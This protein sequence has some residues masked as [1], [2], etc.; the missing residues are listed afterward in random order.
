MKL[1]YC[2]I[3]PNN[4]SI[5]E[6][7]QEIIRLK[8]IKDDNENLQMALKI[9]INSA[10][11]AIGNQY[12]QCY[13]TDVAEAITTQGQ[14]LLMY[15]INSINNYFKEEWHLDKELHDK[16]GI[17][18]LHQLT[19]DAVKY[20]DTDSSYVSFEEA[21]DSVIEWKNGKIDPIEFIRLVYKHRLND[22]FIKM[23]EKYAKKWNTE[24]LHEFEMESISYAGIWTSK[25]KY[26]L[27]MAW[28]D[29]GENGI[30]YKPQQK[31]YT[32]GIE[33][34]QSSYPTF[35]R[36]SLF[37]LIKFII[38]K[39]KNF[40]TTVFM[41]KIKALKSDFKLQNI[42]NISLSRNV[43][44]YEK[45]V[46]NDRNGLELESKCPIHVKAAAIHNY[47]L[48]NSKYKSKYNLIKSGNKIKY[49]YVKDE[50][51]SWEVFG[52]A[53]GNFPAEIAPNFDYDLMFS[54]CILDPINRFMEAL[55]KPKIPYNLVSVK[56]LF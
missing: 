16:L 38:E 52:Y 35:A 21:Y 4:S 30:Y 54:N 18:V 27:D 11:G 24:N 23:H 10:Y 46:L 20:G 44:D 14:D 33:T 12:F 8:K 49:Y 40:D 25:K 17:K 45:Y 56:T 26:V 9:F 43:N 13:N 1:K 6:I 48:N 19:G 36:E 5:D 51:K 37:S 31:I 32:K 39:G 53:Q 15:A 22:Y 28:K 34:S 7:K 41:N 50:S 29:G 2:N 3:D 55:G 42:E 47:K